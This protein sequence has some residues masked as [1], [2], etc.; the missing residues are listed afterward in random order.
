MHIERLCVNIRHDFGDPFKI[1]NMTLNQA[2]NGAARLS[3][4]RMSKQRYYSLVLYDQ[5]VNQRF[6]NKKKRVLLS[7]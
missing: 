6:K 7:R 5:V 4:G 3:R 2:T 1:Y